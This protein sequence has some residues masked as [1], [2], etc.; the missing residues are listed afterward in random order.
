MKYTISIIMGLLCSSAMSGYAS[1]LP[2]KTAVE[3]SEQNVEVLYL[4]G[5]IDKCAEAVY[6]IWQAMPGE[7]S[8]LDDDFKKAEEYVDR[9]TWGEHQLGRITNTF[10]KELYKKMKMYTHINPKS[11]EMLSIDEIIKEGSVALFTRTDSENRDEI[12]DY[13]DK[14]QNVK[15]ARLLCKIASKVFTKADKSERSLRTINSVEYVLTDKI[16]EVYRNIS[17]YINLNRIKEGCEQDILNILRANVEDAKKLNDLQ[18]T[19]YGSGGLYDRVYRP[20]T[21][22]I[23]QDKRSLESIMNDPDKRSL[24]QRRFDDARDRM[25]AVLAEYEGLIDKMGLKAYLNPENTTEE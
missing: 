22:S 1:D 23:I 2:A 11:M 4:E 13:Y 8:T 25:P 14:L 12:K 3:I 15:Y 21:L 10:V 16:D 7:K 20:Y 5:F 17:H 24:E 19:L 6:G 18:A 9:Y